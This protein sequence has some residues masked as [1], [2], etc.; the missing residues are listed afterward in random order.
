MEFSLEFYETRSGK[1]PVRE[2]LD[3]VKE[4]DPEGYQ[5]VLAGLARLRNRDYHRPPLSKPIGNDLYELRHVG[6]L[7][8]RIIYF[9]MEG[10]RIILVHGVRKK[11]RLLS[12]R[13]RNVALDRKRDWL[14]RNLK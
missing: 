8:T 9:F 2:F 10:Q 7:N 1:C 11:A 13:D 6:K 12:L 14:S 5:A 3:Q 4:S